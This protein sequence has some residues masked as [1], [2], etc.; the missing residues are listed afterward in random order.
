MRLRS[1]LKKEGI[2]LFDL[3]L[4][5]VSGD[6][7]LQSSNLQIEKSGVGVECQ[8]NYT[9]EICIIQTTFR[10]EREITDVF[11]IEGE[12]IKVLVLNN[13]N[14]PRITGES[15][16]EPHSTNPGF[17]KL[18][19]GKDAKLSIDMPKNIASPE[20]RYTIIIMSYSFFKG[21]MKEEWA[22]KSEFYKLVSKQ[23]LTSGEITF[24]ITF[25]LHHI[26]TEMVRAAWKL[27]ERVDYIKLKIKEFLLV[28]YCFEQ[29]N[30]EEFRGVN[31]AVLRKVRLAHDYLETNFK[32][33]PTIKELA[34]QVLINELQLKQGF[35]EVYGKTIRAFVIE[36]KMREAVV[37]LSRYK[38]NEIAEILG[39]K[40]LPHFITSFKRHY[41]CPPSQ[42]LKNGLNE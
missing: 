5:L 11:H 22:T 36:L 42:I 24:P 1:Y 30:T 8:L 17:L 18:G 7:T 19:Y 41:G 10:H 2:T 14:S 23:N 38:V 37:L 32:K 3:D 28:L 13:G 12:Y 33:T 29:E 21:L 26:I 6:K 27:D 34:R 20:T 39:Y 16:V 15:G 40:S 4:S 35:K 25:P 31:P 9:S